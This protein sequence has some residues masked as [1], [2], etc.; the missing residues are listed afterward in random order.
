MHDI[1]DVQVENPVILVLNTQD[2]LDIIAQRS[3]VV[4]LRLAIAASGIIVG[5]F[6]Q[7][8]LF[9]LLLQLFRHHFIYPSPLPSHSLLLLMFNLSDVGVLKLRIVA[10]GSAG[11]IGSVGLS[12]HEELLGVE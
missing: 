1:T 6:I 7:L 2:S 3:E 5:R 4:V 11:Y 9:L 8:R 12:M 10:L